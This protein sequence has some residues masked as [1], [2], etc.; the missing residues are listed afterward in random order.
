MHRSRNA[1]SRNPA[2]RNVPRSE[3]RS[4]ASVRRRFVD[5]AVDPRGLCK[6]GNRKLAEVTPASAADAGKSFGRHHRAMQTAGYLFQPRRQIDRRA[7]A[8]EVEPVAAADIAVEDSSDMQYNAEA[9]AFDG[10]A[11]PIMHVRD[12]GSRIVSGFDPG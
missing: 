3:R 10:F 9:K 8:G 5:Q 6:A 11:V 4:P 12:P 7:D 2:R 1:W